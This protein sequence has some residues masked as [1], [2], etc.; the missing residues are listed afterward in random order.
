MRTELD[1]QSDLSSSRTSNHHHQSSEA[2]RLDA[3]PEKVG[4]SNDGSTPFHSATDQ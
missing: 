4:E 1:F 3:D 2:D